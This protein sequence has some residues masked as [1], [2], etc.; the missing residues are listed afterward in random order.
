M[1]QSTS[2]LRG[3]TFSPFSPRS[4]Y[5]CFN[6]LPSCE[7]RHKL[8]RIPIF[9]SGFNPLPS[10]EGRLVILQNTSIISIASI[11]F[12]LAREDYRCFLI[13][14]FRRVLQSTSLLRGKTPWTLQFEVLTFN[15]SIHFP[16]ARED[17]S[18]VC[19]ND[20]AA[21]FNPL[22]SCEGRQ[23]L[24]G[25]RVGLEQLQSTSLLRGKTVR[26]LLMYSPSSCFNP[27]PSCEGRHATHISIN[28]LRCFNP[29]PSC[30]GRHAYHFLF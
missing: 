8:V 26:V 14:F 1:L 3:K 19:P 9:V 25:P 18:N 28:A 6:P 4:A 15:A 21:C 7:G 27:L 12:P 5:K 22:P 24:Q 29:L 23:E 20:N 30:E 2:L 11:H 17:Q 13:V 16:L 10:C